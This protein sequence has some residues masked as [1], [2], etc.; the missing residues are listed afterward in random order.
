MTP[1]S[2]QKQNPNRDQN[3]KSTNQMLT[4]KSKIA[5]LH[6]YTEM[7]AYFAWNLLVSIVLNK[8]KKNWR[9]NSA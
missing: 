6:I 9:N 8:H 5:F 4:F 1:N 7:C 3:T 2:L